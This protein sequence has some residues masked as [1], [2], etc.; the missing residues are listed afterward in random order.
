MA[1]TGPHF[2]SV[3]TND[4]LLRWQAQ[5]REIS[6]E[7]TQM[8]WHWTVF[9]DDIQT[10]TEFVSDSGLK[11]SITVRQILPV[12]FPLASMVRYLAIREVS[13][14]AEYICY[15]DSDMKIESP[16]DLDDAIRKSSKV[17]LITHPGY[18]IDEANKRQIGLKESFAI[19]LRRVSLGSNGDWEAR[20]KSTAFVQRHKRTNYFAGGLFFGPSQGIRDLAEVCWEWTEQDLRAGIVAKWHDESYLNRWASENEHDQAGTEFCH[21]DFPWLLGS[22]VVVRAVDKMKVPATSP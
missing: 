9:T 17:T 4:Y 11:D 15:I 13:H 16:R 18:A 6:P 1:M 3:A 22:K 7:I 5:V 20:R 21:F 14:E 8:G 2:I 10:A 19:L 12:G